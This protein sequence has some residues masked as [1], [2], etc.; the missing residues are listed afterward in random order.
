[1][2]RAG[3]RWLGTSEA[4]PMML[5]QRTTRAINLLGQAQN[6]RCRRIWVNTSVATSRGEHRLAG[7]P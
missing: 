1:M 6:V 7:L 4:F 3:W 2:T 5:G